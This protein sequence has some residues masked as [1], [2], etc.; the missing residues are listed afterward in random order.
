MHL[1]CIIV[2]GLPFV[3]IIIQVQTLD[4]EYWYLLCHRRKQKFHTSSIDV[5]RMFWLEGHYFKPSTRMRPARVTA[6]VLCVRM[7]G[8]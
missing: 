3:N 1:D 6:V 8:T 4:S 2:S 7:Y 5:G